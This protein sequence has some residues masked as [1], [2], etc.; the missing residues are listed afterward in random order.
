MSPGTPQ[1]TTTIEVDAPTVDTWLKLHG[2][3][4]L[5]AQGWRGSDADYFARVQVLRVDGGGIEFK[6]KGG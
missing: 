3:E 1:V 4:L 2:L 6:V 5:R